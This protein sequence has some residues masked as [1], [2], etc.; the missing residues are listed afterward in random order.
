M[1]RT[2]QSSGAYFFEEYLSSTP[3]GK[4]YLDEQG[5]LYL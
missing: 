3:E 2:G 4:A 1:I 5:G